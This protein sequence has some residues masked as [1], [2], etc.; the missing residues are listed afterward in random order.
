MVFGL[1][2]A[3]ANGERF[4]ALLLADQ[5]QGPSYNNQDRAE[6]R[7]QEH[8]QDVFIQAWRVAAI[9]DRHRFDHHGRLVFIP[10][11]QDTERYD[12]RANFKVDESRALHVAATIDHGGGLE[13]RGHLNVAA[14][15]W[16][17]RLECVYC[18]IDKF[19]FVSKFGN[20]IIGC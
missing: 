3:C 18:P 14:I 6:Q 4:S 10:G 12:R 5:Q 9:L 20:G 16:R 19:P 15:R 1:S 17:T 11:A 7:H 13:T 8:D 2:T